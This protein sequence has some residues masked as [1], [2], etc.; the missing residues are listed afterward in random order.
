M[1]KQLKIATKSKKKIEKKFKKLIFL[2]ITLYGFKRS[3]IGLG[4]FKR[5]SGMY[6][7]IFRC[8]EVHT[9]NFSKSN[10]RPSKVVFQLWEHILA[11]KE[12]FLCKM[13]QRLGQ[14][15]P[16]STIPMIESFWGAQ[17]WINI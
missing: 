11:S 14:N 17:V 4:M 2:K 12:L 9:K 6:F 7:T 13:S 16:R 5:S 3:L 8:I 1:Q 10:F 15:S